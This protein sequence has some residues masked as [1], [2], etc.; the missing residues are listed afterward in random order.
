MAEK[1]NTA[2]GILGRKVGMTQVYDESGQ[3]VPVTVVQAGPATC[4]RFALPEVDGYSAVQLGYLDKPRRLASRSER[5]R[6]AKLDSKR[7][8]KRAAA[9]IEAPPKPNC[10]P[11]RFVREIRGETGELE[12]GGQVDVNAFAEIAAVD[13]TATSKG[14]GYSG[15]MKRHNFCRPA[16]LAW[17]EEMSPPHGRYRV[18]VPARAACSR[19]F[20]C[21]ASMAISPLHRAESKG[22]PR[23]CRAE[24]A[25]DSRCRPG[26]QWRVRRRSANQQAV[27]RVALVS[28]QCQNSPYMTPRARRSAPIRSSR[29]ISL[30]ASTSSCCTTPW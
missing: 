3:V 17:R 20:A 2:V 14:R 30:R 9:G 26:P 6:V 22:C 27:G 29:P 25:A 7:S 18:R 21:R 8:K 10:E 28:S 24:S 15:A 12:V 13:V 11:K 4:C 16:C 5:G 1:N 19:A 23:R